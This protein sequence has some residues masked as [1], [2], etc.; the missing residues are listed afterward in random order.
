MVV[1]IAR[2]ELYMSGNRSLK[3][4]R[5]LIKSLVQR[6]RYRFPSLSLSEVDSLDLKNKATIGFGY[7]SNDSSLVNSVLEK[8][9]SFTESTGNFRVGEKEM[10][11]IH[12]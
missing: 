5:R 2:L 9:I 1:G 11:I 12:F 4:K 10:D 7:V 8:V 6:A 3:D